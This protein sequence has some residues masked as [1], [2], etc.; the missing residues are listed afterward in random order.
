MICDVS[1]KYC[2][3]TGTSTRG[4]FVDLCRFAPW[5]SQLTSK[6]IMTLKATAPLKEQVL[7]IFST[8]ITA[9]FAQT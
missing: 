5:D 3:L 9:R 4:L 7:L 1:N 2:T 6:A 8:T